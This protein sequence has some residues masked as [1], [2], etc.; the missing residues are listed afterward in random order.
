MPPRPQ[1]MAPAQ[2]ARKALPIKHSGWLNCKQ[3]WRQPGAC[4]NAIPDC[5]NTPAYPHNFQRIEWDEKHSG[6][7]WN[8]PLDTT[9]NVPVKD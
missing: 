4:V 7:R 9:T 1:Q 8:L 5:G 3:R 6:R 2:T